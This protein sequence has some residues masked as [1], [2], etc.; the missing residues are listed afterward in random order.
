MEERGLRGSL[1]LG[2]LSHI[3]LSL[4]KQRAQDSV[5]VWLFRDTHG[6]LSPD[7]PHGH[8]P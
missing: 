3:L 1:E 4:Q 7:V 6:Q 5:T 8:T 2:V